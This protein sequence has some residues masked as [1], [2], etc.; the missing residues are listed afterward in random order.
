MQNPASIGGPHD[1]MLME[2][3]VLSGAEGRRLPE[4]EGQILNH[5]EGFAAS[6]E[7]G[8]RIEEAEAPTIN[9]SDGSAAEGLSPGGV[10]EQSEGPVWA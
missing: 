6:S 9:E 4:Q 8:V 7:Q 3:V 5:Y 10:P 2:G 1:A